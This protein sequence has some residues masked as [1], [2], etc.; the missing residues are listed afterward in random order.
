MP[1]QIRL[2]RIFKPL[3]RG[4]AK[5]LSK[6]GL[7]PNVATI[8]MLL[9]SLI[10]FFCLVFLEA[11][12]WFGIMVFIT[13]IFDGIDG[14]L[15]RLNDKE[16]KFGGFFDSFMDR[17]SEFIIL[18]ALLINR[19][20]QTLWFIIDMKFIIFSSLFASI[21]ISYSRSR[22]ETF[23]KWDYDIGLMARS[24]RLFYIFLVSILSIYFGFLNEFLFG[25][26]ILVISTA[27]YRGIK[28]HK[29]IKL[30][31]TEPHL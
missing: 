25:F 4:L 14:A 8:I 21:M 17:L 18:L 22:A 20:N 15:A 30:A 23:H 9:S 12:F 1:S 7:T 11:Y 29:M 26:L 10:S 27:I 6:I 2:R 16:T 24:E 5:G 19:W 13:G 3:I 31:E 28:I